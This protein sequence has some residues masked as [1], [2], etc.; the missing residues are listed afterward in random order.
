M[1]SGDLIELA[2]NT[3]TSILIKPGKRTESLLLEF[4]V[5]NALTA[6]DRHPKLSLD[7]RPEQ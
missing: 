4:T 3:S 6:P 2:A 1:N 5:L 7:I